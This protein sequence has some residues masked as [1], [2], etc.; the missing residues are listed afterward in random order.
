MPVRRYDSMSRRLFASRRLRSRESL[1]IVYN[2]QR[3]P[4]EARL[5][6]LLLFQAVQVAC[7]LEGAGNSSDLAKRVVT[8]CRSWYSASMATLSED[9]KEILDRAP[10]EHRRNVYEMA[11][12][13]RAVVDRV[14]PA[15][16]AALHLVSA[17]M[18]DE[19]AKAKESK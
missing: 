16:E 17:E 1:G 6:L 13:F 8:L 7:G 19:R 18:A 3:A 4:H 10:T 5:H 12:R 9:I 2:T 15:A 14:G 11:S